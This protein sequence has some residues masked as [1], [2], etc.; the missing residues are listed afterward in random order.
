MRHR[1]DLALIALLAIVV[2]AALALTACQAASGATVRTLYHCPMHPDYVSD[3]PGDCP[4][5]GMRLV[6]MDANPA[7]AKGAAPATPVKPASDERQ[8]PA[9]RTVYV[10]PMHHD[11]QSDKPGTCPKCG[12]DLEKKEIRVSSTGSRSATPLAP[13]V[14]TAS[15]QGTGQQASPQTAPPP[16]PDMPGMPGMAPPT[17]GEHQHQQPAAGNGLAPVHTDTEQADLA[18]V[19]TAT[20]TKSTLTGSIRTVGTVVTPE[21]GVRQVTT[22]V[23]GWVERLYVNSIGRPVR[24]GEP[25]FDLYSPELLA[26]Q[27]EYLH[28]RQVAAEFDRS[29]IVIRF[30]PGS[31]FWPSTTLFSRT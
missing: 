10:C 17:S 7:G 6:P 21:T 4:I 14:V 8:A 16:M 3:R 29:A 30:I 28:A 20:A 11:V 23:T 12:M 2:V 18:G 19:R 5:C 26:S 15:S 24:A 1:K 25:L 9:I 22:K 27:E 31:T 13:A